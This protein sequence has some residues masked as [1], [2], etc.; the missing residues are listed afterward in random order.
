[1]D[2]QKFSFY[3][4]ENTFFLHCTDKSINAV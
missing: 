4:T 1:L 3:L 2:T